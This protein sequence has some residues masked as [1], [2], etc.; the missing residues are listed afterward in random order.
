[1]GLF[2]FLKRKKKD[3]PTQEKP[4]QPQKPAIQ[5]AAKPVPPAKPVPAAPEKV[6]NVTPFC[7]KVCNKY[8]AFGGIYAEGK[9]EE[10]K[11]QVGDAMYVYGKDGNLKF[12]NARVL[13]INKD[14]GIRADSI[15]KGESVYAA[16][17]LSCF[18]YIGDVENDDI[19]STTKLEIA[20]PAQ[21]AET[22][23]ARELPEPKTYNDPDRR[24]H[25][26]MATNDLAS[27][28]ASGSLASNR[29]WV[30]NVGQDLYDAHGFEAMQEVFINVKTRYPGAQSQLSS[31]WDG[32]GGWAD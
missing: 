23:P 12:E 5:P 11:L 19:L 3:N 32:V 24:K 31:I 16:I 27:M 2:D 7:V 29:E 25:I 13:G 14:F 20:A 8:T 9:I 28:C 10:G 4:A 30:R 15:A 1:M 6:Q 22:P 21:K 18:Q 26:T 17:R